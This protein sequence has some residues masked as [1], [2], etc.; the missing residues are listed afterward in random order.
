MKTFNKEITIEE[1]RKLV[2]SIGM[3]YPKTEHNRIMIARAVEEILDEL[4]K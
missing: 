4:R 2:N 3:M 1:A